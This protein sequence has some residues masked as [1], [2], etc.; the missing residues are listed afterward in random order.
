VLL[1]KELVNIGVDLKTILVDQTIGG[2]EVDCI[3][4]IDGELVFFELKDKVFSLGNAYSCSAKIRILKPNISVIITTA[5]VGR[6][7]REHLQRAELAEGQ[8]RSASR[9]MEYPAIRYIEGLT[10]L[11]RELEEIV[12]QIHSQN[13]TQ[14]L[15][16]I[17]PAS[18][19]DPA[20]IVQ[21]L[22]ERI[23]RI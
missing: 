14:L 15:S 7:A 22:E 12:S 17:W 1:V 9:S 18:M 5:H 8:G 2:D 23:S 21:S 4:D 16:L 13:A 6:D 11:R 20:G 10:N 3:S 19:F